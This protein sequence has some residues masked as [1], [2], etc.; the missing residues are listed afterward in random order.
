MGVWKK[1]RQTLERG[2][3]YGRDVLKQIDKFQKKRAS[4]VYDDAKGGYRSGDRK[5]GE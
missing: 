4:T 1:N 5:V 2:R 3:E